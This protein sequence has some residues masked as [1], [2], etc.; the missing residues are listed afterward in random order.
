LINAIDPL[1]ASLEVLPTA[2]RGHTLERTRQDIPLLER[3][4]GWRD[5]SAV[6][7]RRTY[8]ADGSAYFSRPGPRIVDSLEMLA[9]MIHSEAFRDL[10]IPLVEIE[11]GQ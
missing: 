9:S 5:L 2:A 4:L 10:S 11:R 1:A 3:L 7:N 6:R 8:L